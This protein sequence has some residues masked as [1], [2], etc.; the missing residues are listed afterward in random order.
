MKKTLSAVFLIAA[1]LFSA[2]LASC[3]ETSKPSLND[4]SGWEDGTNLQN[5]FAATAD[6]MLGELSVFKTFENAFESGTITFGVNDE[7]QETGAEG[8][9]YIDGDDF[10]AVIEAL[11]NGETQN[12]GLYYK[13]GA[14]TVD[15]E[16]AA[17]VAPFSLSEGVLNAILEQ[18]QS[19]VTSGITS[20]LGGEDFIELGNRANELFVEIGSAIPCEVTEE[21]VTVG[22]KSVACYVTTYT[23][24]NETFK[25]IITS[26]CEGMGEII[27]EMGESF[28]EAFGSL[29]EELA[30]S[31]DDFGGDEYFEYS[32]M[33]FEP[34]LSA[35]RSSDSQ[36]TL[37]GE[38]LGLGI[39]DDESLDFSDIFD[40]EN[41]IGKLEEVGFMFN[42]VFKFAVSKSKGYVVY[43]SFDIGAETE[44]EAASFGLAVDHG[45]NASIYDDKKIE[46]KFKAPDGEVTAALVWNVENNKDI[47][48]IGIDADAVVK[49]KINGISNTTELSVA[50]VSFEYNKADGAFV[51]EL[52]SDLYDLMQGEFGYG[53]F[54]GMAASGTT[55][56]IISVEGVYL[57]GEKSFEFRIN[58][59]TAMD[60]TITNPL[61]FTITEGCEMP[62]I[63]QATALETVEELCEYFDCES[64]DDLFGGI[65]GIT[66][67]YGVEFSFD[68]Y[69]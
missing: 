9:V 36:L 62:E 23:V 32:D 19:G 58:S 60:E 67:E 13:A 50:N 1:M 25:T 53:D 38:F 7:S 34:N 11:S 45:A 51:L 3:E 68:P 6:A 37:L 26:F 22:G 41:I 12:I 15:M 40:A 65:F 52:Y 46:L 20:V 56:P 64:L 14:L 17:G 54:G 66:D 59:V 4:N 30:G 27:D 42:G 63:P 10:A 61:W 21:S 44:G 31:F 39:A 35:T 57:I 43:E 49:S 18:A 2:A 16:S 47:L 24:D 8:T 33:A 5:A 29:I 55:V 28:A 69:Y 48:N